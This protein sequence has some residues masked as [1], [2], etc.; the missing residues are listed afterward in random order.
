LKRERP[1]GAKDKNLRKQK[2]QQIN[3][4][5]LE[6]SLSIKPATNIVSKSSFNIDHLEEKPPEEASPEKIQV[7]ENNEIFL[8]YVHT[9]KILD[10]NKI[11]INN[12]F[13]FKVAFDITKSDDEIEP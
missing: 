2:L 3:D 8:N 4:C 13:V 1:V 12:V 6:K 7:P 10:Q 9:I 5:T 11:V